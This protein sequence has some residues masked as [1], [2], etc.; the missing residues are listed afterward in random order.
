MGRVNSRRSAANRWA[1]VKQRIITDNKAGGEL[2][3]VKLAKGPGCPSFGLELSVM[4]QSNGL[5]GLVVRKLCNE[6]L[7]GQHNANVA[8]ERRIRNFCVIVGINGK[9]STQEMLIEIHTKK[10]IL[11]RIRPPLLDDCGRDVIEA[12]KDRVKRQLFSEGEAIVA[13]IKRE[14]TAEFRV[15]DFS[16]LKGGDD[17]ADVIRKLE[18]LVKDRRSYQALEA[19]ATEN[20][21]QNVRTTQA[22]MNEMVQQRK[23]RENCSQSFFSSL[24]CAMCGPASR[25]VQ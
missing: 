6:G 4:P 18:Q 13:S 3:E 21:E 12:L 1:F 20:H 10:Q 5:P 17:H 9:A 24:S 16:E 15:S 23:Q 22:F 11:M 19:M 2:M 7:V 14:V 8:P 25:R